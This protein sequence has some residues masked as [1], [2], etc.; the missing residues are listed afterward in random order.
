MKSLKSL[1]KKTIW[2]LVT[3][4][5]KGQQIRTRFKTIAKCSP[6][7]TD[8]IYDGYL[9]QFAI[10]IDN[11]RFIEAQVLHAGY[12]S[13]FQRVL[14]QYVPRDKPVCLDIGANTGLI[15]MMLAR[16]M[17]TK[18]QIIAFEASPPF[19]KRLQTNL[20][21][22]PA[23][24]QVVF[25]VN[26]AVADAPGTL[27]WNEDP[28]QKGNG[29]VAAHGKG[30]PIKAVT[31]DEYLADHPIQRL[32]FVKIDVEG[33]EHEVL[34]GGMKTWTHL[35]PVIFFETLPSTPKDKGYAV[36]ETIAKEFAPI[37]YCIYKIEESGAVVKSDL[38]SLT[39]NSLL[40]PDSKVVK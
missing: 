35:R 37:G 32:D 5:Y 26:S 1:T 7:G 13:W 27:Y 38:A 16:H 11:A 12:E 18:G 2:W 22:N 23:L 39:H 17:R 21:L 19:F 31:I 15:S 10:Q 14:E 20:A 40:V 9:N 24:E 3:F 29:M 30:T 6:G 8:V 28:S 25:P 34:R 36:W 33:F 4:F